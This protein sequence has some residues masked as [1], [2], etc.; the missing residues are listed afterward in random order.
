[1]LGWRLCAWALVSPWSEYVKICCC[2]H[3]CT[4]GMELRG[5]INVSMQLS[6]NRNITTPRGSAISFRICWTSRPRGKCRTEGRKAA[7]SKSEFPLSLGLGNIRLDVTKCGPSVVWNCDVLTGM[8]TRLPP[9]SYQLPPAFARS[10]ISLSLYNQMTLKSRN[11][12]I[13]SGLWGPGFELQHALQ[14]GPTSPKAPESRPRTFWTS[15]CSKAFEAHDAETVPA[16]AP[17]SLCDGCR[18]LLSATRI[19]NRSM[20]L[21][22]KP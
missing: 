20:T 22:P 4:Q 17:T 5:L 14:L 15:S 2:S 6:R 19:H 21:N 10:P 9:T 3:Y 12:F 16:A 13:G 1:M 8:Q 18:R 7:L 11:G